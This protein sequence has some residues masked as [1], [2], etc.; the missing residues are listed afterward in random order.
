MKRKIIKLTLI[1]ASICIIIAMILILKIDTS[2]RTTVN[3]TVDSE[4]PTCSFEFDTDKHPSYNDAEGNTQKE[5]DATQLQSTSTTTATTTTRNTT[6]IQR[7]TKK[8]T[9]TKRDPYNVN[10]YCDPDDFYYDYYDD[11]WDYEDAEDYYYEHHE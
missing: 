5:H 4:Y 7:T 8:H 6:T 10:D 1:A 2:H 3:D 11:F 9:T